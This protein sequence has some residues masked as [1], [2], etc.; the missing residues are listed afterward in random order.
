MINITNSIAQGNLKIG[1][2]GPD[3]KICFTMG[4]NFIT[5]GLYFTKGEYD[6]NNLLLMETRMLKIGEKNYSNIIRI[7]ATDFNLEMS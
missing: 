6:L 1:I 3:T 5:L 7:L 2:I 4:D